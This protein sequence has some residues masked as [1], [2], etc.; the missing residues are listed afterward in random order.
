MSLEPAAAALVGFVALDQELAATEL[1]AI[2]MVVVASAGAL[3]SAAHRAARLAS[4]SSA[5]FAADRSWPGQ[6][7]TGRR[8]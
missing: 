8:G 1:L 5:S 7:I 3:R 4:G 2:A 6:A